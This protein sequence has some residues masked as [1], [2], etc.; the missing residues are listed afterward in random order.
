M[1]D[2]DLFIYHHPTLKSYILDRFKEEL[3]DHIIA[4]LLFP[5]TLTVILLK[6]LFSI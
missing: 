5:C 1:S 6:Q 2:D 4:S 3:L